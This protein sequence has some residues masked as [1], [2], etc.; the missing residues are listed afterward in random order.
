M[1]KYVDVMTAFALF[2]LFPGSGEKLDAFAEQKIAELT[3]STSSQTER[4]IYDEARNV[5]AVLKSMSLTGEAL[6]DFPIEKLDI[7]REAIEKLA[8]FGIQLDKEAGLLRLPRYMGDG[9]G[10][11]EFKKDTKHISGDVR[12]GTV[13]IKIK[14][15][16]GSEN[17][18]VIS[19]DSIKID[20]K[21]LETELAG[22]TFRQWQIEAGFESQFPQVFRDL[23]EEFKKGDRVFHFRGLTSHQIAIL[24]YNFNIPLRQL[25]F[26]YEEKDQK[27]HCVPL[28]GQSFTPNIPPMT[29]N[30]FKEYV[31]KMMKKSGF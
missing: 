25:F 23:L 11:I 29:E 10:V 3:Q 22:K 27:I 26:Q 12:N 6:A 14:N 21:E 20:G 17:T 24:N 8:E 28:H 15:N 16:D 2:S 18:L 4:L 9:E 7:S 13:T 31:R 5:A 30:E 19:H 1:R